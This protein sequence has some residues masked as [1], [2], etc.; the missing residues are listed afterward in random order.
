M[1]SYRDLDIYNQ[2][3][4][5][6][7]KVHKMSLKL[8]K[9]ELYEQGSQIRRSSKSIK[10]NIIE[11]YG[12]KRYKQDFIKFLTYAQSSCDETL[13]H[14]QM[15]SETHE[16]EFSLEELVSQYELLGKKIYSFIQYVESNWN[17]PK[18]EPR[19]L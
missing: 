18:L 12:R 9:Y 6:A 3:F 16:L 15:I 2:A 1:K 13:G 19:N 7:V 14:L 17:A 5:L 4:L 10:D 8:P 11:G